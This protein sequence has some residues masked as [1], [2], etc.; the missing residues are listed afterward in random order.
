MTAKYRLPA[1]RRLGRWLAEWSKSLLIALA[2]W[3]VLRTFVIE[4]FR[5]DSESMQNTLL[6]DDFLFVTKALY[7]AEVPLTHHRLPALRQPRRGD[8]VVFRSVEG[9]FT[10]VKRLVG[11]PGDTLAMVSGHLVRNGREV[12]EP[13]VL[14]V[15]SLR[16][17]TPEIRARMRTWQLP[18][19]T[20]QVGAG[21]NPDVQNWGPIVVPPE[22]LF[23]MGDNRDDSY[24][25]R[26]WGFLP[27]ANLQ[28]SPLLIYYSFAPDSWHAL[29][30]LTAPRLAR[31]LRRPW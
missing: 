26:Y 16:S 20:A 3:L 18:H 24:D 31:I 4:S 17:E 13:Y 2:I 27:R 6:V 19:V 30:F 22:S 29:P 1:Y 8:I 9:D 28:G 15:D 12:S 7:G 25:S 11:L 10:V 21:Y 14:H 5:I 23:V